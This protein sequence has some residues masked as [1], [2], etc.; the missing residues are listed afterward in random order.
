MDATDLARLQF[1]STSIYHFL[2]V[3]VTIGLALLI[4]IVHTQWYR[5][6]E[7]RYER[8][9]RFFG[10]LLLI[11][12][13]VGVVTG[14]VQEFQFG[15][16]WSAYS[17]FVGDVFGA[18]LAME[19]LAA[20]FLEST[21]LGLWVFG[22]KVLPRGIH[23]LSAWLV[24]AG[25]MLSAAF[26]MAANSW[27][28]HPVGYTTDAVTGRAVLTSIGDLFTNPV[29][30]WG[31]I[32]VILASLVTGAVVML[33]VSAW[34]LRRG[35]GAFKTSAV[36]SLV[37]LLPA[38]AL[39][40]G[41][42]SHLGVLETTYQPMKIAA[43]EGQWETCQPCSFSLIQI[44]GFTSSDEEPVKILQVP[45]LLSLLATGTWDGEV[46]GLNELQAQDEAQFGEG[47]YVPDVAI[48]YWSMRVMAYLGTLFFLF[49]AW[50]V[51][52]AVR[53]KLPSART[54]LFV[55][56]WAVPLLFVMNTAGWMLTESGRQP[57]IVQGLMKTADGVSATVSSTEILL[58][59]SAFT[60]IYL[61]LI[62]LDATLIMRFARRDLDAPEPASQDRGAP[63]LTY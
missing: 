36:L 18:P 31:Y 11:N 46:V 5:S 9:T 34:Q 63:A 17:V 42:G 27:M 6:K 49:S 16:N 28:Q 25:A 15:M 48:Q 53:R 52:L 19:G 44:G 13:A 23:L 8:L 3:P 60:A 22:W 43:A 55:A 2:F 12:V 54:F 38:S 20:F 58:S 33:A 10:T 29:F 45:H 40:L 14:L 61:L 24:A 7:I 1:A 35:K 32:H 39:A 57:W 41:V 4:A 21:F 47:D 50:G 56:T 62:V 30:V 37:V 59:I 51:W 26:I